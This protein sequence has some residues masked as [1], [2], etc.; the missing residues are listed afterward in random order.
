[1]SGR[2]RELKTTDTGFYSASR[3]ESKYRF[4]RISRDEID[5]ESVVC[6]ESVFRVARCPAM[7]FA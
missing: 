3:T 5:V 6:C 1:V 2:L 4:A 7:V